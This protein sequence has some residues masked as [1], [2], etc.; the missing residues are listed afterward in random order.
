MQQ[1]DVSNEPD[2]CLLHVPSASVPTHYYR[3]NTGNKDEILPSNIPAHWDRS[4]SL[5]VVKNEIVGDA[6]PGSLAL[7]DRNI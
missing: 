4:S 6:V 3:G 7:T 5:P 1:G 2:L